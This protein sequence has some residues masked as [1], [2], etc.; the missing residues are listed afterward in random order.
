MADPVTAPAAVEVLVQATVQGTLKVEN[1][2]GDALG[3]VHAVLIAKDSGAVTHA[4]LGLGGFLGMNRSFYPVPWSRLRF[5]P[6]RDVYVVT[7]DQAM[8]KGGPSWSSHAPVFD[9]AYA[10]RVDRYYAA[11]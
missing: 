1:R 3:H 11:A 2:A 6:V 7:L 5:D 10:E 9:R 4:V 8:L